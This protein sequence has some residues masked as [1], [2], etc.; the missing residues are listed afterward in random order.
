LLDD[1]STDGSRAILQEYAQKFSDRTEIVFNDANSGCAFEQW[2]KGLERA[3]TDLV[4]IAESDDFCDTNFLKVLVPFFRDEAIQIAYCPTVFVGTDGQPLDFSFEAYTAAVD[5]AKWRSHYVETAHRE[6]R[7][8]LG[9][10]NT[11]PNVSS[12]L[13][14]HPRNLP[15]LN[16]PD[17]LKMRVCGDWVFYLYHA[18]GGKIAYTPETCNYYRYHDANASRSTYKQ[19]RYYR[20]HETVAKTIARLYRVEPSLFERHRHFLCEHWNYVF[21]EEAPP[22]LRLEE[23]YDFSRIRPEALDRRPNVLMVGYDFATGGGEVFAIRLAAALREKGYAVTFYDF[24]G[25]EANPEFRRLLPSN[26]PVVQRNEGG[27]SLREIIEDFGIEIVHTHHWCTDDFFATQLQSSGNRPRHIVTMHGMYEVIDAERTQLCAQQLP[28]L[29]KSVDRWVYVAD[30][31][32]EPFRRLGLY[33]KARFVKIGY[34]MKRPNPTPV[35]R[36]TL[37]IPDDA[38]VVCVASRAMADKGWAESLHVI[39]R[40]RHETSRDIHLILLGGGPVCDLLAGQGT[41]PY[42]HVLGFKPNP[43]DYYAMSNLGLLAT[44]YRSE[45]QPLTIIECLMAGRPVVASDIGEIRS[46]LTV[47]DGRLAGRLIGLRNWEVPVEEFSSAISDLVKDPAAY[48]A[49][50]S[51]T[52]AASG[53]FEIDEIAEQYSRL[54]AGV[55]A[56]ET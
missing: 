40:A 7:T 34:G 48:K 42:V 23:E 9:I 29:M 14:R 50:A 32:L 38:F 16:D 41:P 18:R 3:Q 55:M 35:R 2:K 5:T 51:L 30:K 8:A 6:V 53:H 22:G 27:S 28:R 20:E 39:E 47:S 10:R 36:E 1:G 43:V 33:D 4:W 56:R 21:K 17:W 49:A 52:A 24:N 46:M 12:V 45:C 13:L 26:V 54:Y 37:G 44:K 11:I 19:P 31:N 25:Q 15:L